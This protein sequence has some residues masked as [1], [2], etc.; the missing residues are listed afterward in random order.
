[1][2]TKPDTIHVSANVRKEI[3]ASH[4]DLFV[5][6]RGSSV[7]SGNEA[8]NKAKE[9]SALVDE[10]TRAGVNAK[11]VHLQGV[12]VETSS[13]ALLKSSSAIYR[14]RI[15]IATLERLP[16]LIDIVGTQKNTILERI[17]WRYED[18]TTK[19]QL[20]RSAIETAKAKA[21]GVADTLGVRLLGV[22]SFNENTFDEEAPAAF[23]PQRLMAKARQAGAESDPGLGMEIQHGKFIQ[24]NVEVEYRVS[25]LE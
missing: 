2:E 16:L 7:V 15:H 22:Y 14:L 8:L 5:A 23:Q 24:S 17:A 10:L 12:H 9:V 3:Y 20:L 4:A 25:G 19:E 21:K 13:G 1:M 18:E 6:V 11:D